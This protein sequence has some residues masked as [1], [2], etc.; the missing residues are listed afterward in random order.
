M[1]NL[2]NITDLPVVE[3]AEGL[4]LIVNDNGAAKQIPANRVGKVK[5]IN[6]IAPDENGNVEI[7][8]GSNSG[9]NGD[10]DEE[11]YIGVCS[12]QS[13]FEN[14]EN[15]NLIELNINDGLYNKLYSALQTKGNPKVLFI[16]DFVYGNF[17]MRHNFESYACEVRGY[18]KTILV[19]GFVST[20]SQLCNFTISITPGEA[21]VYPL[22]YVIG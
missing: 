17:R 19:S 6:G 20:G 5:T 10:Y 22:L 9:V 3:S 4:N 1:A 8:V 12:T 7:E 18:D 13:E 2:K 11:I 21:N 14:T 15:P 16:Y